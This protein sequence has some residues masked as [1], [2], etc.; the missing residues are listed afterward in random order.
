NRT[1]AM[2][3]IIADLW[4]KLRTSLWFVPALMAMAGAV[5]AILLV[6]AQDSL[7]DDWMYR[8]RWLATGDADGARQILATIA[9]SVITVTGVIFSVT[10]VALSLA[11]QQFGPRLLRMFMRDRGNQFVL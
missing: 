10:L 5:L 11:S 7:S 6:L 2:K 1:P 3:T 8:T 9:G 4:D